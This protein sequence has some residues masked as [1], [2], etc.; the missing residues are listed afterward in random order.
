[1]LVV[2]ARRP[3]LD[4]EYER[5]APLSFYTTLSGALFILCLPLSHSPFYLQNPDR[6]VKI[7]G[8]TTHY[9]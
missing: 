6:A 8:S 9:S 7:T 4:P 5:H 3:L 2:S 1:M